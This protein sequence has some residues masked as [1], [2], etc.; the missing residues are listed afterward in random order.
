MPKQ[1]APK[2]RLERI[3]ERSTQPILV[4]AGL[5]VVLYILELFRIVPRSLMVPFLWVNF[6]IDFIFLIDLVTKCVVLGRGYLRS[7]WFFIDFISTLPIISSSLEI[8]GAAGPQLQATR[9]ARGARVARIARVAR[10]ARLAKVARVARLATA[11]RARHG[12]SFLKTNEDNQPTPSFNRALF[13]GVPALLLAFILASTYITNREVAILKGSLTQRIQQAQSQA[14]LNAIQQEYDVATALNPLIETTEIRSP[15]NGGQMVAVSLSEAYA[16]ADRLAGVLLLLVLLTI[17][18]S[19]YISSA[20]SKDRSIGRERSIL[21]QCF[22]PPIVQKF[23][24]SPEVIE[25]FFH[26]WMT[27]FFIDIRGFTEAFEKDAEDVEGLALKLR[28]V[29]DTAR[30]EIVVTH[31]GVIDKFMGDAVMGWVGGHFS[32]HWN[33][34]ADVRRQL[35]LDDLELIEQDIKSIQREIKQLKGEP[36]SNKRPLAELQLTLQEAEEQRS[37]LKGRQKV[38]LDQNSKLKYQYQ[39]LIR[40]YRRR[41]AKSAV[42]CCLRISQEVERIE[43]PEAFHELKIGI[44]SGE[45]LVGNFG[46]TDQIGFTVLGPTVNRSAR[47]EPASAQCGCK[48]LIDQATYELLKEDKDLRFRRVPPF[49]VKGISET[50]MTYEPFFAKRVPAD[51]LE[52]FELG[53]Q[54][55]EKGNNQEA[56][57][58]FKQAQAL[59]PGGD[60]ASK[61]WRKECEQALAEERTVGVKEMNK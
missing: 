37:R 24:N 51:F 47:L 44:G 14:E 31:E 20:L 10:V 19:V 59:Y 32:I 12:L 41:V 52:Q 39:E 9:V 40:E 34:L 8:L 22:S 30:N 46:S 53:V 2:S 38:A 15:L 45:V 23:Y 17:G 50:L 43:D 13:I 4:L 27:V 25:R 49:S 11:I 48:I 29:M 61:L 16:K 18:I 33:I 5:A 21:S 56:I 57:N 54:S 60:A 58:F 3:L 6:L 28:Q 35:C 42:S 1:N 26:Q 7:P 36:E 55:L